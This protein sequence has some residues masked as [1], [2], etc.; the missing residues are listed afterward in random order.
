MSVHIHPTAIVS[1]SAKLGE[2][3]SIGPYCIVGGQA[4]LGDGVM[5][6]SH[7][8]I[9]GVTE[10]GEACVIHSFAVLGAPPQ[11]LGHRGEATQ[12]MIGARNQIRE[13]AT[14]H[15]GTVAG[16]GVTRVGNDCLIMVGAHVAHDAVIG[17]SVVMANSAAVGGH[18]QVGD[19][20]FLGG[21]C[22]IHQ[23]ARVGR[24]AFVGTGSTVTRDVIPYGMVWGNHAHL[25]GLNLVGL[26]RRGFSRDD[27]AHM[28]TAYRLMFADE[29][30]FQ[31]RLD[32]AR[33]TYPHV[34]QV[35]EMIDFI[36]EDSNRPICLPAG[37]N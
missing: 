12:L 26:K 36:R 8:I 6:K 33:E 16:G 18:V 14:L 23:F 28:R 9:D 24:Y 27:I 11:H 17:N 32:E 35:I 21:L 34:S 1:E 19:F 5:L 3:V 7:V 20:V 30:T 10:I 37:G 31:E 13:H 25:E 15:C 4:K 22:G 29:G 2:N